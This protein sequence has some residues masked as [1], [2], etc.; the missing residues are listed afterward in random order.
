MRS[1]LHWTKHLKRMLLT[2]AVLFLRH[3]DCVSNGCSYLH[4]TT[5]KCVNKNLTRIP[6]W[7]PSNITYLDLSQNQ[8]LKIYEISLLRFTNLR[9]LSLS[10]CHLDKPFR[11]P[12]SLRVINL[13]Y[14]FLSIE[15]VA[16]IF[17]NKRES[18]IVS[19]SITAN[20]LNLEGNLSIF[21][22]TVK[23][24]YLAR[25]K[26]KRIEANDLKLLPNLLHLQLQHAGIQS[27]AGGAFAYQKQLIYL[28]L[29]NN[30]IIRLP[31]RTFQN[32][33]KLSSINLEGNWLTEVPDLTGIENLF[34]LNL[35]RN[36][37]TFA[38]TYSFGIRKIE[39]ILLASNDIEFF[40]FTGMRYR[41]LDMANNNIS[42]IEEG[43]LGNNPFVSSLVLSGNNITMLQNKYFHG[44]Y[45]IVELHLQRNKLHRI[46]KGAFRNMSIPKLLLFD[47]DLSDISGIFNDMKVKPRLLLLFGNPRIT[48][49]RTSDYQ[50]MTPDSRIYI[51]CHALQ[52]F[53]SPF[54]ISSHLVCSPSTTLMIR[55]AASSLGGNG[56]K[57]YGH[58]LVNCYPCKPGEYDTA[59]RSSYG[60]NCK[61]CPYGAFYQDEIASIHCKMCPIGQY[62]SP[63]KGPGKSALDCLTCPKGTNTNTSAGYRACPCLPG[64]SRTYR[65]GGCK[66]C[67]SDGF[68]CKRDYPE[69]IQGY[70]IS[71]KNMKLCKDLFL[72]FMKNLNTK[73]DS[74]D[75][76]TSHF[77]C[78]LPVAHKCPIPHS[79]KGGV[80]A[81]CERGYTGVLCAVCDSGYMKQFNKCVECPSSVVSVTECVAYFMSFVILCWLIS[82]LDN[83]TLASQDNGKNERS[84]ADLIQASLKILMGFYQVLVR[85]IYAFS[86]IQ[87]PSTLTNAVKVFE[88][89]QVTVLKIPSLHCIRSDWKLNAISEF[90]I[91]LVAMAAVPSLILVYG[92]FSASILSFCVSRENFERKW[93]SVLKNCLQSIV[94]FF[95]ATYLSISTTIFHV[96]PASCHK[97]CT[98]KKDGQCINTMSYL[99]K[100]YSVKCPN[101]TTHSHFNVNY[102][103]VSL[104]LPFG[105]PCILLYLLWRF[106]PKVDEKGYNRG[107]RNIV[108]EDSQENQDE[109][110]VEW[111]GYNAHLVNKETV[112]PEK[113]SVAAFALRMMYSNYKTSCWYWEL[114]E[115]MRKLLMVIASSFLLQNIKIGLYSNILLSIIFVVLHA[116]IWP[117]KDS[118]DNYMQLLALVS[119]TVNLCYSVTKTSSIGDADVMENDE[120]VFALGLMLVSLNS[121]LVILIVGRF[122]KEIALKVSQKLHHYRCCY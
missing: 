38:S 106:A 117:M 5:V 45:F 92:A 88:F 24:L 105:L 8:F 122:A 114:I 30:S 109:C 89:I 76:S 3:A 11:I 103:Y 4:S 72:S 37:I 13:D 107:H 15:S 61:P 70:W 56:F 7:I 91:S 48:I 71:W 21:P 75:S 80:Q 58:W 66:K 33:A 102:A 112:S 108:F 77:K 26:M 100:D 121:L 17:N 68:Q 60:N 84:F 28:T 86:S 57:C 62:V 111:E 6:S 104:L 93:M 16:A 36:K 42:K 1:W 59:I 19:I 101:A 47:N 67:T 53:S 41:I 78:N 27:I 94:L 120:D 65:F 44:I 98:A 116:K 74:Y 2:F 97:I 118:F 63:D 12:K 31:R 25:N 87:W 32:C 9:K 81:S 55:A 79:C 52:K 64:Y 50:N 14:N 49:M 10:Y 113:K 69:L 54:S 40:N 90:W 18:N 96:L 83:V 29:R 39:V 115:M 82:K 51:S 95:F 46:E 110:Y 73:N 22:T 23:Y 85:I 35:M 20:N 119:V 99:R 43:S 34:D